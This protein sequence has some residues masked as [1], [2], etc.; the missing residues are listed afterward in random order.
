[1][2]IWDFQVVIVFKELLIGTITKSEMEL[3]LWKLNL[4]REIG[5]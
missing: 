1:M 5:V 3:S 4:S 2:V